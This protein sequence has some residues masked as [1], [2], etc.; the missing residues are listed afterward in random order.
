MKAFYTSLCAAATIVSA[1]PLFAQ[2]ATEAA[3]DIDQSKPQ[4]IAR[5]MLSLTKANSLLKT[6]DPTKD[7]RDIVATLNAPTFKDENPLGRA[8]L[9]AS[10]YVLLL[11]QPGIQPISTRSA[12]GLTTNPTGTIDLYAAADSAITIV[13]KSSPGCAEYI[14]PF[15]QQKAW[16]DVTNSAINALNAK[17]LDS[18]EIFARRSITLERKS[19]YAYTVLASVAKER[20]NYPQMI[21]YSR[22][23]IATSGDDS[24]YADVRERAQYELA[25]TLADRVKSAP[26]AEKKAFAKE[27]IAAWTPLAMS[28]DEVQG[29]VAVRNLHELYIMAGDSALL[30]NIYAPMLTNSAKYSEGALLQAGVVASQFQRPDDA[31]VLFD[32]VVKR[33]PY[34]RDALNNI[35]A[36]LLQTEQIDQ[37]MPF[38]Q[39]LIVLDPNNPD[40]HMFYAYAYA[41]KLKKKSDAKTTRMYNDSLVYWNNVSEKMPVKVTFSEFSRNNEGTTLVGTIENRGT[42]AKSYTMSVDFLGP[43]GDVL[44]TETQTVGPIAPKSSKAFTLKNPKGVGIA[45]YRYKSVL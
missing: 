9:L 36:S 21:E 44:F 3:C 41:G 25:S 4:A 6:G 23:V 42:V 30:K 39:K 24:T 12:V 31:A 38:I 37:A 18:A 13:E 7:L 35:A 33:N 2:T 17:Q 27:A 32:A 28:A 43:K 15:R 8:F 40:N 29:T 1:V 11:E 10:A 14:A 26:A 45:G 19:P 20:K 16:L 22:Q 5:S 34:S